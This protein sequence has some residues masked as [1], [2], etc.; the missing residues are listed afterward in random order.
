MTNFLDFKGIHR[1]GIHTL[2]HYPATMVPDM[3]LE[4]MKGWSREGYKVMLDPFMGSGTTLVEAQKINLNTIGID[5]NPYAILLSQV[6]THDYSTVA[7]ASAITRIYSKLNEKEYS[8]PVHNFTKIDKWFRQD[9]ILDLSKIRNVIKSENDV[10]IRRFL[11]ICM[12]ETIYTHSNDRTSS[13]KLHAKPEA[14]IQKIPN[15]VIRDFKSSIFKNCTYLR[16]HRLPTTK[17]YAGDA[18]DICTKIDTGSVDMICTSPP[19]GENATTVT[20]GQ[21]SILF[22]K[23]IDPKDLENRNINELLS[24]FSAIDSLSLGGKTAA[25]DKYSSKLLESYLSKISQKKQ[26][27]IKRFISDYW[28]IIQQM[29]RVLSNNGTIIM[30]LGNRTVDNC[31]QPLDK[32]T[33][34]MFAQLGIKNVRTY[35]RNIES[36]RTPQ[37]VNTQKDGQKIK[38]FN[39]EEVLIFRR[40]A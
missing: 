21:S 7:W 34:E 18:K 35:S 32:L 5:L 11:W 12:S 33:I 37:H 8:T 40:D 36:R 28:I 3:Q 31:V 29:S 30:T 17:I 13:F 16:K 39:T 14:I 19:Y 20:Y 24:N 25:I 23:W 4:L 10:W 27:K 2:G 26:T 6:K 38:S 9:I 1:K 22:L 15:N